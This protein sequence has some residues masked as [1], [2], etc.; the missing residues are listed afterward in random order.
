MFSE[1]KH[2]KA[3]I[4]EPTDKEGFR[5][6]VVSQAKAIYFQMGRVKFHREDDSCPKYGPRAP[7]SLS[8]Q[9]E[10]D[11]ATV[12]NSGLPGFLMR[13]SA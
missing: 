2:D 1:H 3:L 13:T 6:H 8:A 9:T 5:A 11:I 7:S 12:N 4:F 10:E